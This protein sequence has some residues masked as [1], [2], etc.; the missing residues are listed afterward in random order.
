MVMSK[1]T[2]DATLPSKLLMLTHPVDV[3][4][5][6]GRVVGRF[7]PVVDS[8][9]AG[10]VPPL[11]EEELLRREGEPDFSTAEVLAHLENL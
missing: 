4:D 7:I 8:A 1:L 6:S 10:M 2:L 11:D 9:R 3:C 5:S